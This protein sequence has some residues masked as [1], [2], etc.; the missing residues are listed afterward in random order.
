MHVVQMRQK[1]TW[2]SH[3]RAVPNVH[4]VFANTKPHQG[5]LSCALFGERMPAELCGYPLIKL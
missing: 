3:A 2:S 5:K 4:N 1:G